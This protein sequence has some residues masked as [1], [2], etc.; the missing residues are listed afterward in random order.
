MGF[1]IVFAGITAFWVVMTVLLVRQEFGDKSGL[2]S[3]VA[4]DVVWEKML[5]A[6]D[7]SSLTIYHRK[8]KIGFSRWTA[9][10]VQQAPTTVQKEGKFA[11]EGQVKRIAGYE[12]DFEGNLFFGEMTNRLRFD[13]RTAISTNN[14]WKTI[15]LTASMK[16]DMWELRGNAA[17]DRITFRQRGNQEEW[18]QSF[19]IS[20]FR[21]PQKLLMSNPVAWAM[22]NSMGLNTQLG[23]ATN[24]LGSVKWSARTDTLKLGTSTARV[25]RLEATALG[26]LKGVLYVSRAGEILRVELPNGYLLLNEAIADLESAGDDRAN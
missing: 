20:D 1:R 23:A 25:Y 12:V 9:A 21:D 7:S 13:L 22:L 3:A 19:R 16:P 2:E 14:S 10:V 17:E 6:P 11:S 4:L 24:M 15:D 26:A 18:E 5:T 8:E